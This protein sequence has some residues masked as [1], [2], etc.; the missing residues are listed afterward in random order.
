MKRGLLILGC[1]LLCVNAKGAERSSTV[2]KIAEDLNNTSIR[3]AG[4]V[5]QKDPF[6]LPVSANDMAMA[7]A[8]VPKAP[9]PQRPTLL[10]AVRE[11][12]IDGVNGGRGEFMVGPRTVRVGDT[13]TLSHKGVRFD[14]RVVEVRPFAVQWADV[15]TGITATIK[16]SIIPQ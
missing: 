7:A 6:G 3:L 5:R 10:D 9:D 14:A 15:T 4:A 11:L 12:K 2:A 16:L 8:E 1:G 13:L